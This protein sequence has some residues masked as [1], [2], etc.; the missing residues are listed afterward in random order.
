MIAQVPLDDQDRAAA[1]IRREL[2]AATTPESLCE[3]LCAG[4]EDFGSVRSIDLLPLPGGGRAGFV[5]IVEMETDEGVSGVRAG[6]ELTP[7]GQR[8]LV[9]VVE[10]AGFSL[11]FPHRFLARRV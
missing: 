3:R 11:A 2:S 1:G 10:R 4:C 7:F 8:S 6:L 5:C 9:C